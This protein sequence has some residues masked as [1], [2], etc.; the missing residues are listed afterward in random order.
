[1]EANHLDRC[2]SPQC[3]VTLIKGQRSLPG[4][5]E[6]ASSETSQ[7]WVSVEI[8]PFFMGPAFSSFRGFGF[9][10]GSGLETDWWA[11]IILWPNIALLSFVLEFFCLYRSNRNWTGLS[12]LFQE[13]P[14][15]I[16]LSSARH[17]FACVVHNG[18]CAHLALC[19]LMLWPGHTTLGVSKRCHPRM[20]DNS[21]KLLLQLLHPSKVVPLESC[22]LAIIHSFRS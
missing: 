19:D 3:K 16:S 6:D 4:G 8:R 18:N 21:P 12:I 2:S 5:W 15:L 10:V 22:C 9:V 11:V 14:W 7:C 1:M 13:T 17:C 20:C